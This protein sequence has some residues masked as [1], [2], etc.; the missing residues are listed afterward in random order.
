MY[1]GHFSMEIWVV[2]VNIFLINTFKTVFLCTSIIYALYRLLKRECLNQ[3]SK[4]FRLLIWTEQKS[5]RKLAP[6]LFPPPEPKYST[7][8]SSSQSMCISWLR[9]LLDL[10]TQI[11]SKLSKL[12]DSLCDT[13]RKLGRALHAL[14]HFIDCNKHWKLPISAV[15]MST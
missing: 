4:T 6:I 10:A 5:S 14:M 2:V 3:K 13:H 11:L 7:S 8:K 15:P 12:L 1:H 9:L